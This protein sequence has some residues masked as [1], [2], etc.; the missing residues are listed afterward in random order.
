MAI[1][2]SDFKV[3]DSAGTE[4]TMTNAI[5]KSESRSKKNLSQV[6]RL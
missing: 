6:N 2:K 4:T 3:Q 5:T 1:R